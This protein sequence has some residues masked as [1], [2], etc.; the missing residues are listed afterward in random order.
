MTPVVLESPYKGNVEI[1]VLYARRAMHHCLTLNEAP[2][3][4]HLLYTQPGVLDDD[5]PEQR[6]LGIEAGLVWGRFAEKTVVYTDLGITEGMETGIKRALAEGR[7]VEYREIG[8]ASQLGEE[9]AITC[10]NDRGLRDYGSPVECLYG[11]KVSIRDSS[12][13]D[14]VA[15]WLNVDD[16]SWFGDHEGLA[17]CMSAHIDVER[18]KA[19]VSRLRRWIDVAECGE[20]PFG[21]LSY[22]LDD[23][24]A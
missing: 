6:K 2:L 20:T 9:V 10:T 4:S 15:C 23:D 21:G 3:A 22:G 8:V 14:H 5:V 11:S 24:G 18:A 1:N 16:R 7:P 13:A 17:N 19:I 12:S